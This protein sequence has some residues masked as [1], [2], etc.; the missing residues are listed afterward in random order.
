MLNPRQM[1]IVEYIVKHG[2]ASNKDFQA[3]FNL[4]AQ[5]IHKELTTLI[6]AEVLVSKGQGKAAHY[7]LVDDY[8]TL[9]FFYFTTFTE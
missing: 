4:S 2:K 1:Q 8:L 7:V 3:L 5:S 6:E 9:C